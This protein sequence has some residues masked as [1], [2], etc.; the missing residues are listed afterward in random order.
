MGPKQ[1]ILADGGE[2]YAIKDSRPTPTNMSL[3]S[4]H[5]PSEFTPNG[6]KW[7]GPGAGTPQ[8]RLIEQDQDGVEAELLYASPQFGFLTREITDPEAYKAVVAAYNDWLG[9]EYCSVAPD[10]LLGLGVLPASSVDVWT[11]ELRHC[12]ELGLAGATLQCLPSAH[13][14]PTPEDDKFWATA[15]ELEMP[16][17][18]H[19]SLYP[20]ISSPEPFL[21]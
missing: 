1:V 9:Q 11:A 10:R 14:Y 8:E 16:V 17:S 15:V 3:F 4:G 5:D 20:R 19:V 7:E 13:R 12:K 18:V 21:K 2:A 6:A